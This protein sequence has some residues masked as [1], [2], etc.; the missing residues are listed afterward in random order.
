MLKSVLI[1]GKEI[2]SGGVQFK[3]VVMFRFSDL[4]LFRSTNNNCFSPIF[5]TEVIKL[6]NSFLQVLPEVKCIFNMPDLLRS[7]PTMSVF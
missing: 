1:N 5:A 3:S 4:T 2:H 7:K 6:Y